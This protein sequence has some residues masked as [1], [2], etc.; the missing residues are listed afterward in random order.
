[1]TIEG[2]AESLLTQLTGAMTAGGGMRHVLVVVAVLVVLALV[3]GATRGRRRLPPGKKPAK[4]RESALRSI[5]N[6]LWQCMK[7]NSIHV[8][9]GICGGKGGGRETMTIE[10]HAE[11]LLTQLMGATSAGG[12]M[13]HVLVVVAVLVVLALVRGATRGRRRLPPGK[14]PAKRRESASGASGT[15]CG[16]A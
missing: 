13:R 4:R 3:R 10:G 2:H 11:S 7:V 9:T 5:W 14:K 15:S 16:N 6:L 12:G 1:M 8:E